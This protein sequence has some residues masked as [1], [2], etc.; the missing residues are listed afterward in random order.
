MLEPSISTSDVVLR[1]TR[2]LAI[3]VIPILAA[4]FLILYVTPDTSGEHFAWPIKP[5]MSAMMLGATYFTGVI[6]FAV[7]LRA[8]SWHQVRLG[9]LPSHCLLRY[10][11]LPRLFIGI[12]LAIHIHSFGYG[13]SCTGPCRLCWSGHGFAMNARPGRYLPCLTRF[14]SDKQ[15][16]D[17][18]PLWGSDLPPPVCCYLSCH[19]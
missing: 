5:R 3:L 10:S 11:E 1:E 6:Y 18:S 9:L 19:P 8:K 14:G 7:V 13:Y 4:A 15:P 16:G 2:W 17:W 12:A